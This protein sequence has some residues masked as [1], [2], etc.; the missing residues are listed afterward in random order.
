MEK[1]CRARVAAFGI[2]GVGSYTVEALARSG[3]GALD[4]IDDERVCLTY[5]NR[6]TLATRKTVG[7]YK[8]EV[9]RRR[10]LEIDP[11]AVVHTCRTFYA[12]QTAEQFNF[13][14]YDD[15]WMP[16]TRSLAG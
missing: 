8:V 14:Q 9:A 2:R 11:N 10:I 13:I 3:I 12:P 7:Q 15:M 6:Q 4:L 5:P 1:L 16:S